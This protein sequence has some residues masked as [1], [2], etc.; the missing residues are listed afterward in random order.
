MNSFNTNFNGARIDARIPFA[1]CWSMDE[2]INMNHENGGYIINTL[3]SDSKPNAIGHWICMYITEKQ[4]EYFDSYGEKMYEPLLKKMKTY[5]KPIFASTN[6]IQPYNTSVLC[7]YYCM[8]YILNRSLRKKTMYDT[9]YTFNKMSNANSERNDEL[10][11]D[12]L[13]QL[14]NMF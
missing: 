13:I 9:F 14:S 12:K 8:Y 7:G 11:Y 3:F 1:G 10:V 4:I 6:K 2:M 5:N